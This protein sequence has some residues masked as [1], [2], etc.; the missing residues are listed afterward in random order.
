MKKTTVITLLISVAMIC[1]T[2]IISTLLFTSRNA[3]TKDEGFSQKETITTE[4]PALPENDDDTQQ[5]EIQNPVEP[6]EIQIQEQRAEE[7]N[8]PIDEMIVTSANISL[9]SLEMVQ[10]YGDD[11]KVMAALQEYYGSRDGE[12]DIYFEDWDDTFYYLKDYTTKE[13]LRVDRLSFAV[14]AGW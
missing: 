14:T 6:E 1:I 7:P 8:E 5:E 3:N 2:I 9:G 13:L 12:F 4:D 11:D 10:N